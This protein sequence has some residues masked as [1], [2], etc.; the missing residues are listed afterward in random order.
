MQF[1]IGGKRGGKGNRS[2]FKGKVC[3]G[4]GGGFFLPS[5]RKEVGNTRKVGSRLEII[6][7]NRFKEKRQIE[8]REKESENRKELW[9]KKEE[10]FGIGVTAEGVHSSD[11]TS[12]STGVVQ[13]GTY[14]VSSIIIV[15]LSTFSVGWRNPCP[16]D[17]PSERNLFLFFSICFSIF[18]RFLYYTPLFSCVLHR[19]L[20]NVYITNSYIKCDIQTITLVYVVDRYK[21]QIYIK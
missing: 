10:S 15:Y 3:L 21:F 20:I 11:L 8:E 6:V 19:E 5:L 7:G 4:G 12:S 2:G 13:R 14:G 1:E 9:G 18:P 16:L 17:H